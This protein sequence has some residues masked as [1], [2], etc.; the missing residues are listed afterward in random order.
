MSEYR[1]RI[2]AGAF[3]NLAVYRVGSQIFSYLPGMDRGCGLVGGQRLH[4]LGL[5][6]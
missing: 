6:P 5:E 1:R 2:T 3:D 4:D